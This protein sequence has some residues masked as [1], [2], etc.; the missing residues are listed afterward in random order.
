MDY[1]VVNVE[2]PIAGRTFEVVMVGARLGSWVPSKGSTLFAIAGR[3]PLSFKV[4][5][6][7]VDNEAVAR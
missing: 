5:D 1:C 6:F 4:M 7:L 2:R 3:I